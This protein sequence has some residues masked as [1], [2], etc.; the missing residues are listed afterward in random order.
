MRENPHGNSHVTAYNRIQT[1][2][3][4]LTANLD[5]YIHSF[6]TPCIPVVL[7]SLLYGTHIFRETAR[8]LT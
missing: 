8:E 1:C 7:P 6:G 3:D 2:A 4:D 5:S